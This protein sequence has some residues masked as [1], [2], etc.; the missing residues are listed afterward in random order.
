[1]NL[2][3]PE[4]TD[5]EDNWQNLIVQGDNLQFLKTCF[6]NQDPMI[7][8]KVKGKVKLVYIDPPF[9][10]KG[11]FGGKGGEDSYADKVDRTEFIESL[12]ERLIFLRELL[13]EDGSVY[14][15][16]DQ[17]MNH[18]IK[19]VLDEVFGNE[20]FQNQ[21]VWRN[22]NTHNK[23]RT[24]GRIH[25]NILFYSKTNIPY[26]HKWKRPPFKEYLEQNFSL[27]DDNKYYAKA[28]LT[29]AEK[30]SG[31]SGKEWRGYNPTERGRHWAIPSF[32]YE[33][34]E[35][36][37]ESLPVL[38]RLERLYE[39]GFIYFPDKEGGQP[40]ILKPLDENVGNFVMD[41]WAYQPYTKGV[42]SET[43]ECIDSDVYWS[44]T[45]NESFGYPTQKPE[46]LLKRIIASSTA[47]GDLVVDIFAGSGTTAAAAEKLGRRWIACDF[48]KHAI[49]TIQKRMCEIAES[50]KLALKDKKKK[51]KYG[52]PP[53]PFCV[54]SVGAF[55]FAKIMN[56]RKNRDAYTCFVLGIFGIT[57]RDDSLAVKY[58]VSNVCAL[59]DNNPVE[60]FP[61]WDDDYLRN[62]RVDTEYLQDIITQSGGKLKG[63]YY[64]VVP[65]NCT[66]VGDTDLKNA[67]GDTVIFK[68]LTFPYKVLEEASRNFSIEEQPNT[69]DNINKLISSVGFYFNETV[70]VKVERSKRG[71]RITGFETTI[72]DS[73]GKRCKGLE[74]LAMLLIDT[75]YREET[76]F[77]VDA[78]NYAKDIKDKGVSVKG[79]SEKTAVI[80]IDRHGNE[81]PITLAAEE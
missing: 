23:A 49:Y 16:L 43:E 28:D 63:T 65:E 47:Q 57:E 41:I 25:Q 1:M 40:R 60:V 13:A 66:R 64:L 29:A 37:L 59:K 61:V 35:E 62:V 67:E 74:G 76:G 56:L 33:L 24:Y 44:F 14:V 70:S 55:D 3:S 2:F 50:R 68:M 22:T 30:R 79:V 72:L 38:E 27:G 26:F 36:D 11:D 58:R 18:Y 78:V 73:T 8:D 32:V 7:K 17:K 77:T 46:G 39:L 12:R 34:I 20:N 42:Y 53:K 15:H 5:S 71:L 81:S 51:V 54:V 9:A 75:D 69:P 52:K 4:E 21:I 45:K 6:L 10:T 31:Y 19:I 48:G 80:A